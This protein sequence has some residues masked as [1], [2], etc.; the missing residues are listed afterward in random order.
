[1]SGAIIA[2]PNDSGP[3]TDTYTAE[4]PGLPSQ[5]IIV[6]QGGQVGQGNKKLYFNPNVFV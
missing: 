1:M 5:K 4:G 2:I 3:L 6:C